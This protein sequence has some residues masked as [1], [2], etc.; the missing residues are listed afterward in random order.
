M[1][2]IERKYLVSRSILKFLDKT[3]TS[4]K[5][6]TQ[7]YTDNPLPDPFILCTIPVYCKTDHLHLPILA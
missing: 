4:H 7:Y 1:K 6:I 5:N 3:S 2:E